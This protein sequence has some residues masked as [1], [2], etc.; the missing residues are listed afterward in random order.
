MSQKNTNYE[1]PR[2]AI[3]SLLLSL[4]FHSNMFSDTLNLCSTLN[5]LLHFNERYYNDLIN[6]E[7]M[8]M[9]DTRNGTIYWSENLK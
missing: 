2:C 6:D 8:Y 7:D 9:T 3:F 5:A 1:S 4:P